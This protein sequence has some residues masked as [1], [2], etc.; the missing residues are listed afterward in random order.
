MSK[1]QGQEI[2][3]MSKYPKTKRDL[4]SRA[5]TKTEKD[6][7]LAREFGQ[8]FF[9]GERSHG[10]GGFNYHPRFWGPV[11]PDFIKYFELKS[12]DKILDVGCAKGFML[13]DFMQANSGF[14]LRGVDLS[15]YAIENAKP[16]V[17]EL[18]SVAD[19]KSLPFDDNQFDVVISITTLHNLEGDDLVKALQEVERVSSRGSFITVDAYTSAEEKEAMY[20]WNLTAKTILHVDE[21]KKLFKDVGYTGDYFLVYA[22]SDKLFK[23]LLFLRRLEEEIANRYSEQSMRCPTHLSIGQELPAIAICEN[24][25]V[26]DLAVS[27]HRCHAHYLAKGGDPYAFVAELYGKETGCSKGKGGSMHLVDESVGF[28]GATAIVGNSIPV[29]AGLAMAMKLDGNKKNVV[30]IFL[31]EAATETGAF[32]ES[33]NFAVVNKIPLIFACEKQF[34][35]CVFQQK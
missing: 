12:G 21:W 22:V 11:V 20:A 28:M 8:A 24:L 5:N 17:R 32:Y 13:Y 25:S 15:G 7:A 14:K 16:E 4:S 10:Y 29:G 1:K 30:V 26:N 2:D 35:F 19:A 3:L 6:Q 27:T 33:A 9:D 23:K 31:G 34:I 18:C